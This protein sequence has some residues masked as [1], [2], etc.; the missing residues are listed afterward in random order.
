MNRAPVCVCL[1]IA[2][3]VVLALAC[4]A[5][6]TPNVCFSPGQVMVQPDDEFDLSFRVDDCG[7]SVASFQLYVSFDSG[8]VEL[9]DA[10]EGSLY[11]E[12]GHMTW[13]IEEE[14]EPGFWHFFDTVFGAGT[15]VLPPGELLHLRFRALDYGHTQAHVDTIRM[16]DIRRDPLPVGSFEHADIFVVPATG[17]E[18]APEMGP[19]LGPARPNPFSAD[20]SI[21][22][23]LPSGDTHWSA[24]IYD[25]NGRLVRRL[26]VSRGVRSGLLFW[27]GRTEDGGEAPSSVYFLRLW[28][29]SSEAHTRI[30]RLR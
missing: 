1:T 20:T 9:I 27:D 12:S 26:D 25:L 10:D 8:I 2:A 6:A 17:V 11:V 14:Q 29:E 23:S 7:D 13:F 19:R 15:H 24:E 18:E 30:V 4:P 22:F 28:G 3:V 5:L 21:E 16:T